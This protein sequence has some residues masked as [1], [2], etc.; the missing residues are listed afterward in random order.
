MQ[1]FMWHTYI[2]GQA[3]LA[4]ILAPDVLRF[5]GPRYRLQPVVSENGYPPL[6]PLAVWTGGD[7][8]FSV[9]RRI[10]EYGITD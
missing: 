10:L 6:A 4:K 8:N 7:F 5:G 9:G 3:N 2:L 1:R